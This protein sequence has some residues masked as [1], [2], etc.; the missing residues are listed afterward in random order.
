M[1]MHD[2]ASLSDLL[3][4]ALDA[5]RALLA[6]LEAEGSDCF[7]L[8]H[9]A[10]EGRP[11][12]AIDRY[13]S[14]LLAQTWREPLDEADLATIDARLARPFDLPLVWNHRGPA[15]GRALPL[16]EG[17]PEAP[18][19]REL[20]LRYE[21]PPRH[22]G[23]DPLLFLDLRVGRRL[24]LGESRGRSVLNLFAYSCG[25][26]VAAAAGGASEVWNV[27]FSGGALEVGRRNARLNGLQEGPFHYLEQDVL[28]VI[29]QLAG[30]S[31]PLR[32]GKH[33]SYI[34]LEARQFDWVLLDPPTWA[35][36]PFG[37]VDILRDYQSLFK[38]AILATR[39]GGAVLATHHAAQVRLEDWLDQLERC[40]EK[41]GRPLDSL[42]V[43]MPEADFPSPD[44]R[45]PLK[46]AI[47]RP[48]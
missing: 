33:R 30:L 34:R 38:P 32:R 20:G 10:V 9:G 39:P 48:R 5:R 29:R 47:A 19:G 7:R 13:G 3:T 35:T 26:G 45:P 37:A 23:Q 16:P 17:L 36:G 4:S 8:F 42:E 43:L 40:A 6:E 15:I 41:A 2:T 12:L 18:T 14:Y 22:R 21:L 31:V 24:L 28:P 1:G 11:G 44:G 46:I 27:D 25:L